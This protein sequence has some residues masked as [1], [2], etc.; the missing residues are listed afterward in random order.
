MY[1]PLR[2][3]VG[4]E[5]MP[6]KIGWQKYEDV[7]ESHVNSPILDIILS[8]Y[9]ESTE[10]E[11]EEK[12]YEEEEETE[13]TEQMP[14]M[15]PI[16]AKML[17]D[18]AMLNNFECW[19]GHTNFDITPEVKEKLNTIEGIELLKVCSR[20]R[21]FIGIGRMFNFADVRKLIDKQIVKTEE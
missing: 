10:M 20:Y 9:T 7:I 1:Q 21:F 6:R 16:S 17:D 5:D 19:M 12:G 14:T 3:D 4:D 15:M 11:M 2:Y 8:K 18:I 13:A